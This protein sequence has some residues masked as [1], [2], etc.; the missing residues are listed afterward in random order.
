MIKKLRISGCAALLLSTPTLAVSASSVQSLADTFNKGTTS[1]QIRS[2]YILLTPDA[3]EANYDFSLGGQLKFETASLYG[4]TMGA[5]LYTA[6]SLIQPDAED[7]N[8]ELSSASGHYDLLAEAYIGYSNNEFSVLIGRQVLDTPFADRD[9]IR[10]TSH[11]FEAIILNYEYENYSV[12]GGYLATWQGV[13]AGFHDDADFDDMV[14]G[15]DGTWMLGTSYTYKLVESNL[16]YYNVTDVVSAFYGDITVPVVITENLSL[17]LGAQISIQSDDTNETTFAELGSTIEGGLYGFM[18]ELQFSG[19]TAGI[20]Y[21]HASIDEGEV[22]FG[23]FGGGPFFT[24]IDTLVANE[25]AA[26]QD[27]D[28]YTISIGYDC[29]KIGINGLS[30][31]YT[32]GNYLGGGDATDS[33]AVME[34]DEHDVYVAYEISEKWSVD[35]VYVISEDKEHQSAT[36]WDYNRAQLRVTFTF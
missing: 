21:N 14:L 24:N 27:A 25:F 30:V 9:D 32:F 3:G 4:F 13:D 35:G 10:M 22:L 7:F 28:S 15:S 8:D 18:A 5:A 17:T 1:G 26:G 11:T 33:S 31:G 19:I 6:H 20:A 12:Q 36:E 23:G 2:G 16:W 34:V 29:S